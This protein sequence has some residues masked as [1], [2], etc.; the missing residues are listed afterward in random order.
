MYVPLERRPPQPAQVTHAEP[1]NAG[2]RRGVARAFAAG[3]RLA[4]IGKDEPIERVAAFTTIANGR[5]QTSGLPAVPNFLVNMVRGQPTIQR[6]AYNTKTSAELLSLRTAAGAV[7]AKVPGDVELQIDKTQTVPLDT[8]VHYKVT[9]NNDRFQE[10][11]GNFSAD[12]LYVCIFDIVIPAS[13]MLQDAVNAGPEYDDGTKQAKGQIHNDQTLSACWNWALT[14]YRDDGLRPDFI[15]G[16]FFHLRLMFGDDQQALNEQPGDAAMLAALDAYRDRDMGE[17]NDS[18]AQKAAFDALKPGII[19]Q[20]RTWKSKLP[21]AGHD[22][23][24]RKDKVNKKVTKA[25]TIMAVTANGFALANDD[26][27]Q[28]FICMHELKRNISWEHWWIEDRDG[29]VMQKFPLNWVDPDDQSQGHKGEEITYQDYAEGDAAV[30]YTY[31][32]GVI[33]L[34]ARHKE[35]IKTDLNAIL[36]RR[37]AQ[38]D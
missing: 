30:D 7:A 34:K 19:Q 15:M 37:L 6:A 36:T 20:F 3:H 28:F 5:P 25:L 17:L 24:R 33:D 18:A 31:K 10:R 13:E 16:G 12:D 35:I 26:A 1:G 27:A 23:G 29:N 9:A 11:A 14:A 4:D 8:G 22:D 32:I 2:L 21:L 38:H